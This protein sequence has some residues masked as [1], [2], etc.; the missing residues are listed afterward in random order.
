MSRGRMLA[1]G[2]ADDI[3]R[4][5]GAA[6]LEDAFLRLTDEEVPA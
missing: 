4:E 1:L 3:K 5:T 6:A 2:T